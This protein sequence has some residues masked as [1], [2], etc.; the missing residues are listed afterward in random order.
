MSGKNLLLVAGPSGCGK[1][2]FI[3][4]LKTNTLDPTITAVLPIGSLS[5]PVVEANNMMK[6]GVSES[7]LMPPDGRVLVHYDITFIHR[8]ALTDYNRDPFCAALLGAKEIEIV[9]I[10]P[11]KDRLSQ[12]IIQRRDAHRRSKSRARLLFADWMRIPLKRARLKT[13]GLPTHEAHELYDMPNFL[14]NCYASWEAYL[15]QLSISAS[16]CRVHII[17]PSAGPNGA[18]SFFLRGQL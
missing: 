7:E 15:K 5:W 4:Q 16:S 3:D 18:P 2:C 11:R 10:K 13:R 9:Y 1:S 14:D 12:Q 6:N 17:E 8:Y